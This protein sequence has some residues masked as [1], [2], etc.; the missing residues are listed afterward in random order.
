MARR[1]RGKLDAPGGEEWVAANKKCVGPLTRETFESS[2][3][4][5]A[6][7]GLTD[8]ELQPHSPRAPFRVLRSGLGP[9]GIRRIDE[10]CNTS[11]R[12]CQLT[13]KL[14]PLCRQLTR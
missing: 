7:A 3:D 11:G 1:Q 8:F 14:Q 2:L 5:G 9:H 12:G 4:F 10:H 13:K 6:G